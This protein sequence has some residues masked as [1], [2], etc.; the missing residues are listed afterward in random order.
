MEFTEIFQLE[1][2][3][4]M[5]IVNF[6]IEHLPLALHLLSVPEVQ[7]GEASSTGAVVGLS[8]VAHDL[9]QLQ[10]KSNKLLS[11]VH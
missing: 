4:L 6:S 7:R 9:F 2:T 1:T 11:V 5:L 3:T 10:V 8:A